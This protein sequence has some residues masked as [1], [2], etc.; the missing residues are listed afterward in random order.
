MPFDSYKSYFQQ[1][2]KMRRNHTSTPNQTPPNTSSSGHQHVVNQKQTL[3]SRNQKRNHL[4]PNHTSQQIKRNDHHSHASSS[5]HNSDHH[6]LHSNQETTTEI[7]HRRESV[8]ILLDSNIESKSLKQHMKHHSITK[9]FHHLVVHELSHQKKKFSCFLLHFLRNKKDWAE[10]SSSN[11]SSSP[12]KQF[13]NYGYNV[14][15]YRMTNFLY[16]REFVMRSVEDDGA[17]LEFADW[18]FHH[19]REIVEM[20][21]RSCGFAITFA[22]RLLQND[23]NLVLESVKQLKRLPTYS[24]GKYFS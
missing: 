14:I 13:I 15:G 4:K 5:F 23:R 3:H 20:A 8:K 6:A 18:K 10:L 22:S 17:S 7:I 1:Q 19:D 16:D 24:R 2:E 11:S 21:I 9:V 12:I